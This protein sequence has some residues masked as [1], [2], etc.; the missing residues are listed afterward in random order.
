[1]AKGKAKGATFG[2]LILMAVSGL[3]LLMFGSIAFFGDSLTMSITRW[4]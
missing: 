3:I 1:M 4:Y 2:L